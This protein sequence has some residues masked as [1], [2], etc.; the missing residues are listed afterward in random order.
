MAAEVANGELY[1]PDSISHLY[2]IRL[3]Y[4]FQRT[5]LV[6]PRTD[7]LLAL[8][9][10]PWFCVV[11]GHSVSLLYSQTFIPSAVTLT[12]LPAACSPSCM[13]RLDLLADCSTPLNDDEMTPVNLGHPIQCILRE[14]AQQDPGI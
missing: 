3:N 13:T 14:L 2:H 9:V 5:A 8:L 1:I 4:S 11:P 7:S 6:R 10:A 12:P